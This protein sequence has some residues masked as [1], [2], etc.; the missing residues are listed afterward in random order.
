MK[1]LIEKNVSKDTAYNSGHATTTD[2]KNIC[3]GTE[4]RWHCEPRL[5]KLLTLPRKFVLSQSLLEECHFL[6][7]RQTITGIL[8]WY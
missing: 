8:H 1:L 5:T 7:H 2:K 6:A 3:K 4:R